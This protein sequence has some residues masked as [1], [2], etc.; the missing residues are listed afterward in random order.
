MDLNANQYLE[1]IHKNNYC[2]LIEKG[3]PSGRLKRELITIVTPNGH[4]L[5]LT[6]PQ[7]FST[8]PVELPRAFFDQYVAGGY[9]E[10][11]GLEDSQ[12]RILYQLTKEGQTR[13]SLVRSINALEVTSYSDFDS[14]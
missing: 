12:G 2:I 5:R 6:T 3:V 14:R 7:G 4:A 9:V 11:V 8:C 13:G 10:A 1:L